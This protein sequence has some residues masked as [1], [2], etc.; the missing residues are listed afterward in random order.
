[1]N[2]VLATC[3]HKNSH[4][5]CL[6]I[7][8]ALN[9]C[10]SLLDMLPRLG[11]EMEHPQVLVV[12]KLLAI[13]RCKFSSEDPDLPTGLRYCHCLGGRHKR[14]KRSQQSHQAPFLGGV[15]SSSD[16]DGD[17]TLSQKHNISKSTFNFIQTFMS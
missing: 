6:E 13:R 3:A 17:K 4:L 12:V 7:R 5:M 2:T 8:K 1:M 16:R 10:Q 11:G 14:A 15:V 9:T